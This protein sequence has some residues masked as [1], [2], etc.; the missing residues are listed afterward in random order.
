[1]KE[2]INMLMGVKDELSA[3]LQKGEKTFEYL[4]LKT[5]GRE[6]SRR[7]KNKQTTK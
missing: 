7:K 5:K 3:S 4:L 1:M 6:Q 2:V